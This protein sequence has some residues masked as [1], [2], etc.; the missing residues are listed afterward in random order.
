MASNRSY[1]PAIDVQVVIILL[2]HKLCSDALYINYCTV[3]STVT[4]KATCA[5]RRLR[6]KFPIVLSWYSWAAQQ[7]MTKQTECFQFP[8]STSPPPPPPPSFLKRSSSRIL[9]KLFIGLRAMICGQIYTYVDL[10]RKLCC[11]IYLCLSNRLFAVYNTIALFCQLIHHLPAI[12]CFLL[13]ITWALIGK[14]CAEFP[15]NYPGI[16]YLL[17]TPFHIRL[18]MYIPSLPLSLSFSLSLYIIY[19]YT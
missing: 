14:I 7:I 1:R 11:Q 2:R 10:G 17:T 5:A 4:T 6:Q 9:W 8:P 13:P 12:S 16:W 18:S 3:G 15:P 19:I